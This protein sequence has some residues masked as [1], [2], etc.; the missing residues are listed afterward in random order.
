[1]KKLIL[2]RVVTSEDGTFGVLIDNNIPF[3]LTLEL[4]DRGNEQGISCI[5]AGKYICRRRFYNRGKYKTFL[6]TGVQN[7]YD[8]LFH[9]GNTIDD[10]AGCIILAEQYERLKVKD[11]WITA[12]LRSRKGFGEFMDKMK[13]EQEF[14]LCILDF[15]RCPK[16]SDNTIIK[17]RAGGVLC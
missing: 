8:I 14:E 9:R 3:C 17:V 13:D 6:I 11:N 16:K 7:R 1:M 10:T 4:P 12:I 15:T 5:P 2:K